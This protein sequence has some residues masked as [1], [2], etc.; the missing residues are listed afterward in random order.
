MKRRKRR[1]GFEQLEL[2]MPGSEPCPNAFEA[3]STL[4]CPGAKKLILQVGVN[5]VKVQLGIM[6]EGGVTAG[7]GGITWQPH[8]T[9]FPCL[10]SLERDFDAVR[11]HNRVAGQEAQV[12]ISIEI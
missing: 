12:L 9:F 6:G 5:A 8:E 7:L 4:Y 10:A 11:V 2:G 3:L 1:V